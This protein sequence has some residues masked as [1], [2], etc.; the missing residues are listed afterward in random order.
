MSGRK[1]QSIIAVVVIFSMIIFFSLIFFMLFIAGGDQGKSMFLQEAEPEINY[2]IGEVKKRSVVTVT[3]DDVLY[4]V[5]DVERGK[6]DEKVAR[7]IL[8]YY[9]STPGDEI[10]VEDNDVAIP[11]VKSDLESYFRYKMEKHWRFGSEPVDYR[12][13]V[14]GGQNEN[15]VV[16]TQG[17]QPSASDSGQGYTVATVDDMAPDNSIRA[18]LWTSGSNSIWGV[19]Q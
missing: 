2:K 5:D 8:S 19:S 11:E 15:I 7:K 10:H 4:R 9:A 16:Q 18:F 13:L 14:Q 3:M 6:Y 17:Y 1:G 12:L